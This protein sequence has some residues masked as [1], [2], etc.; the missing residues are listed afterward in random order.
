VAVYD[1][2][3]WEMFLEIKNELPAEFTPTDVVHLILRNRP[4]VNANTIR[5]HMM[6]C[7]PN[8]SIHAR[9]PHDIFYYLGGGRYRLWRPNDIGSADPGKKSVFLG[10]TP[11]PLREPTSEV[12]LNWSRFTE[13]IEART[14][15]AKVPCVYVQTDKEMKPIRIGKASKGLQS[16]Y[17]GGTG[18][19]VGA[20]M[21]NAGNFVFVAPVEKA[22]CGDVEDELIWRERDTLKF[23]NVGK[24]APPTRRLI[25]QDQGQHPTWA[26]DRQL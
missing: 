21:A 12:V 8:H 5:V 1:K 14:K 2:K 22:L 6:R 11:K 23:N 25:V 15:F 10:L 3:V 18:Y 20:A 19:T 16:R 26:S 7:T 9:Q 13:F 24:K 17:W 4:T